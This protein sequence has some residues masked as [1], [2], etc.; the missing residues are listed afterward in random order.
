M[1]ARIIKRAALHM[2]PS[3]EVETG[4]YPEAPEP[5][6]PETPPAVESVPVLDPLH[7]TRIATPAQLTAA[8]VR[9]GMSPEDI[10]AAL[11]RVMMPEACPPSSAP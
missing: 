2:R 6:T 3:S 1:I 10:E 7:C 5:E 9:G 4:G 8:G 11:R